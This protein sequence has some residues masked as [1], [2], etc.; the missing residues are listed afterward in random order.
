V[1]DD[2]QSIYAFR[3]A[4]VGNM[5]QLMDD[6]AIA[7]PIKLTRNYRSTRPSSTPPMR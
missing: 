5:G 1:G 4:N 2:D 7:A 6:L 3:G